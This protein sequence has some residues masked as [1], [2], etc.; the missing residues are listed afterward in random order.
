M[1]ADDVARA[2]MAMDDE[3]VRDQVAGGD[4]TG[5]GASGLSEHEQQL[6][7]QAAADD[8]ETSGYLQCNQM[9]AGA[10]SILCNGMTRARNGGLGQA[11]A[12][13]RSGLGDPALA[14][15]FESWLGTKAAGGGW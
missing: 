6:V 13:A 12:Y 7:R 8:P 4:L 15:D 3:S 9:D 11:A 14:K 2:L 10:V 1:A 5:L